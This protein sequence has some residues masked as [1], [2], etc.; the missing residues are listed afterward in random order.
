LQRVA[1]GLPVYNGEA[2]VEEAIESILAQTFA[3]FELIISDN[4]SNDRTAEICRRYVSRDERV[5]YVKQSVNLGAAANH[6]AV[7][8]LSRSEYFKWAAH[9]DVLAP[10]F[11]EECVRALDADPSVVLASPATTLINEDGS[12]LLYSAER[13]G[14]IDHSGVC[15]PITPEASPN[16]RSEDPA[17]RFEAIMLNNF[18]CVEIFGLMRRSALALTALQGRYAG[19]DK[20]ILAQLTLLGPFWLG[21]EPLLF[22]R[23]HPR[24]FSSSASGAYRAEWFAGRSSSMLSQQF[25]LLLGY[26]QAM[27]MTELTLRQRLTCLRAIYRRAAT[28]GQTWRRLTSALVGS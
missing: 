25:K 27:F 17:R 1:I 22:R 26:C 28:R 10:T 20:V 6:N 12:P 19:A 4:A 15:W 16:L 18:M 23:C 3:D 2:F 24:Q 21:P 13:G 7:A 8:R 5:R 14:M 11:L 9:D